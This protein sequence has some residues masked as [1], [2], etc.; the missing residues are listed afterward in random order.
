MS[1]YVK[2]LT[3]SGRCVGCSAYLYMDMEL[4]DSDKYNTYIS[5]E[6]CKMLCHTGCINK[7]CRN[8]EAN[9]FYS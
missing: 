7:T 5:K 4:S 3:A 1:S 2:E 9:N 8:C 6:C